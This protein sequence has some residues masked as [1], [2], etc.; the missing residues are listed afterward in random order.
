MAKLTKRTVEA[1]ATQS[2][3]YGLW[4]GD[5]AAFGVWVTPAGRKS[6]L[7]QYRVGTRSRK[8]TLGP[9]AC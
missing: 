1:A 7:V 5:I 2:A 8:L 3:E 4:D 6:Y 9:M